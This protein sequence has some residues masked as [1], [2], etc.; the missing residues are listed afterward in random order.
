VSDTAAQHASLRELLPLYA[1]GALT[2]EKECDLVCAHLASGC[3]TCA[4]EL[5]AYARTAARLPDALAPV[6]P[7]ADVRAKLAARL[8]KESQ[9]PTAVPGGADV[10]ALRPR[11][12]RASRAWPVAAAIA[13]TIAAIAVAS[14][15]R[16]RDDAAAER[17]ARADAETRAGQA[18]DRA[19]S[20][21][22]DLAKREAELAGERAVVAAFAAGDAKIF[23]VAAK[24]AEA[25]SARISWN[26]AS[27]K[28]AVIAQG[29][30]PA[31]NGQRY[32]LWIVAMNGKKLGGVKPAGFLSP[33]DASG[34]SYL[35][36]DLPP[37]A[38]VDGAAISREPAQKKTPD[39]PE[40]PVT[41][42]G[43]VG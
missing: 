27:H 17:V 11:A 32:E 35:D 19:T 26:P 38:K 28:W 2:G 8:A 39:A 13:A 9:E 40:G 43:L 4:E 1:L 31:P 41:H 30:A 15:I 34:T 24:G 22:S 23:T 14:T 7:R 16:Y 6:S 18:S 25:G 5:A 37:G 42:F 12:S 36:V 29:L 3:V 21:Q 33:P 20:L 10:I